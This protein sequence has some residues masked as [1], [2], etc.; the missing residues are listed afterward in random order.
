MKLFIHMM[1]HEPCVDFFNDRPSDPLMGRMINYHKMENQWQKILEYHKQDKEL[2]VCVNGF[3]DPVICLLY[4][5]KNSDW[6]QQYLHY[7][8][9]KVMGNGKVAEIDDSEDTLDLTHNVFSGLRGKWLF[10]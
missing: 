5:L 2:I 7:D 6:I 4:L 10:N 9:V 1:W 8:D 3:D